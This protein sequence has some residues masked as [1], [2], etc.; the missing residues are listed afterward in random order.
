M[1]SGVN[2]SQYKSARALKEKTKRD[3]HDVKKSQFFLV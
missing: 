3:A 2:V 1:Q